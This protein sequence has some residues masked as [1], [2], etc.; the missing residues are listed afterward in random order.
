MVKSKCA[1]H[2][3]DVWQDEP[4]HM[5]NWTHYFLTTKYL[6]KPLQVPWFEDNKNNSG[7]RVIVDG[8]WEDRFWVRKAESC[9]PSNIL[10]VPYHRAIIHSAEDRYTETSVTAPPTFP[11]CS[12]SHTCYQSAEQTLSLGTA[13]FSSPAFTYPI[14]QQRRNYQVH[15]PSKLR[16]IKHSQELGQGSLEYSHTIAY[17]VSFE[18][19]AS[20]LI[21][22]QHR[23]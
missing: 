18:Q 17:H 14:T 1:F 2:I 6:P 16:R 13:K 3:R 19:K 12:S 21:W 22:L 7:I 11:P 10:F 9:P 15:L 5:N 8:I 23:H 20:I 4:R